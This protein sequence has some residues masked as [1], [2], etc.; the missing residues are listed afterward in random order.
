[1]NTNNNNRV[2]AYI[3]GKFQKFACPRGIKMVDTPC[4]CTV[5]IFGNRKKKQHMAAPSTDAKGNNGFVINLGG[6]KLKFLPA[7]KANA[8]PLKNDHI[9][10]CG[11]IKGQKP[12]LVKNR[13]GISFATA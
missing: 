13:S 8:V 12:K 3:I 10:E 7:S 5:S 1:M 4:I 11:H 2:Q 9:V 6:K